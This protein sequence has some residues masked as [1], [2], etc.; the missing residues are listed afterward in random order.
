MSTSSLYSVDYEVG[1]LVILLHSI[2]WL[3][4]YIHSGEIAIIVKLHDR[5]YDSYE[6]YDCRI[7][8]KCGGEIDVWFGEI[9]KLEEESLTRDKK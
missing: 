5:S 9:N 3:T 6:I 2:E 4:T 7:R 8:L 1:D